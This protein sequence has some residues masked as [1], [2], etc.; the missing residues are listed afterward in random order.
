[1]LKI[2][3]TEMYSAIGFEML[4]ALRPGLNYTWS[5]GYQ[6]T[7]SKNLQITFQY[8]GRKSENTKLSILR[9]GGTCIFKFFLTSRRKIYNGEYGK[10]LLI[11]MPAF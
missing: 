2:D 11:A 1:M 8:L 9:H 4:E 10:I 5:I 3:T 6:K 7:V